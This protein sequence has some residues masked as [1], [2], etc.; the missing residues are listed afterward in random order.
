[1]GGWRIRVRAQLKRRKSP[2]ADEVPYEILIDAPEELLGYVHRALNA[3][4]TGKEQ[5][6]KEWL[7]GLI[8]LLYKRGDP[9]EL[10]SWRP[11]VLLRAVY[12]VLTAILTDRLAAI[13]EKY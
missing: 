3:I 11:V 10:D 1:M 7:D 13:A 5:A 8:R 6:P 12:K 9:A 4:L 2:G